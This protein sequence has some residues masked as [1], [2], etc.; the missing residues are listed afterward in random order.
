MS[1]SEANIRIAKNTIIVYIRIFVTIIVGLITSRLVLKALGVDD[2]G[3][4]N[5]VGSVVAMFGFITGALS[6]T[7]QRFINFEMGKPDGNPGKMFNICNVL[8]IGCA[9]VLLILIETI[10]LIYI[11]NWLNV[12]PGKETDAMFVF[13]VSTIVACI[14][15][16]NIP[17][18]SLFLANEKF[19]SVAIIDI[20]LN[21][22]KLG[23]VFCL[24]FYKG[25]VLRLYAIFM[26]VSTFAS[27]IVYHLLCRKYWPD[28]VKW[29]P[30]KNKSEYKE[31][32]SFNNWNLLSS[33]ALLARSQGSNMLINFFFGTAVNAAY[34][35][36]NTVLNY[37]NKFIGNFDFAA[38]PQITQNLSAGGQR[39]I[40][41]SY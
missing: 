17:Y 40:Q 4:Y 39:A 32:L 31:A 30:V 35:I 3:L 33:A 1:N 21:L 22:V 24:L 18:Q 29:R 7:T 25:N 26:S 27:F 37:I 34:G 8:H 11:H 14:G 19:L 9:V 23:L 2:Y 36:A 41:L 28:I 12:A 16:M 38:A 10:G 13:Q 5:V 6:G 15:I 20:V